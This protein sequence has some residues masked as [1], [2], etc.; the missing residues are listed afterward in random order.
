MSTY[1]TEKKRVRR[2]PEE[3]A[4]DFDAKI[5]AV[6]H[7]IADLEAKKQAAVS[8][9]DEKIAAARKRMK[10]LEEKKAAIFAPKPKRK[11]RKT[12]KQKIQD[13]LKQ[14]QKAGMNPQEIAECLG[15]DFEG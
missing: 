9:Y 4:A 7:T 5:E 10:V 11:V 6:N 1:E 15:I 8:S 12:K 13:I 14:A 3:R 2:S